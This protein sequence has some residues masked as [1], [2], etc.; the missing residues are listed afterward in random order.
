MDEEEAQ[1]GCG[2]T[3]ADE[4]LQGVKKSKIADKSVSGAISVKNRRFFV[5]NL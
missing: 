3:R 1:P 2:I 5:L 4:G